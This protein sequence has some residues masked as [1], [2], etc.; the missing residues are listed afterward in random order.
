VTALFVANDGGHLQQLVALA[1]RLELAGDRL[2][3]TNDSPQSQSLLADERVHH[4]PHVDPRDVRGVLAGAWAVRRLIAAERPSVVV[5]TGASI[6]LSALPVAVAHGIP[7][8]YVESATRVSGP[9]MTGR[10]LGRVPKIHLYTQY[11]ALVD[12]RWQYRG[13]VFDSFEAVPPGDARCDVR[14]LVV[15]LGTSH[16]YGFRRL[17]ERMIPVAPSVWEI[18]WQ[19]GS[20]D[21]TGLDIEAHAA[22]PQSEMRAQMIAADVV[23]THAG[24]GSAVAALEAGVRPVLVPREA[25]HGEHVDDHQLQIAAELHRRGLAMSVRVAELTRALLVAAAGWQVRRVENPP[26][27]RLDGR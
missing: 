4:L 17:I 24:T 27:I 13:S 19:T 6:A 20:T 14:R 22:V 16:G 3:L 15:S 25:A 5:S 2:W 23:V 11:P 18:Y 7:V 8:H 10:L 12:R 1:P 9:S 26:P 21:V